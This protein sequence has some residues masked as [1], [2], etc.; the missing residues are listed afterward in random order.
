MVDSRN[1]TTFYLS[2]VVFSA[3]Y[4]L[5]HID[6]ILCIGVRLC[7]GLFIWAARRAHATVRHRTSNLQATSLCVGRVNVIDAVSLCY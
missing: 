3:A 6:H 2:A 1:F 7:E 4:N 5:F